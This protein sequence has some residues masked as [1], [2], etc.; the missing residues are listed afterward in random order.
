MSY[1]LSQSAHRPPSTT[2][3]GAHPLN[4]LCPQREQE[5]ECVLAGDPDIGFISGGFV[6]DRAFKAH[7]ELMAVVRGGF[8]VIQDGLMRDVDV[9][10]DAHD[11]S[12]FA[13]AHGEGDKEREDKTEHVRRIINFS[14]VDGWF[15]WRGDG[16]I[17]GLE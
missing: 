1:W 2:G 10:Y 7:V 5:D 9:E 6:I 12:G 17:L 16:E 4:H 13:G 11:I 8:G 15:E 3:L 14:D